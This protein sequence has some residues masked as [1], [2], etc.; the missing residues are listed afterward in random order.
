VVEFKIDGVQ[1]DITRV[2]GRAGRSRKEMMWL[3]TQRMKHVAVVS[4]VSQTT[5]D[6]GTE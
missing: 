5:S 6:G 2:A 1:G 4:G 3:W